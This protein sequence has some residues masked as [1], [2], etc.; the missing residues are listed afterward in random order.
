M[1]QYGVCSCDLN[2]LDIKIQDLRIYRTYEDA[3]ASYLDELMIY[4]RNH[5][6]LPKMFYLVHI[7]DNKIIQFEQFYKASTSKIAN[8]PDKY[9]IN[10]GM[11]SKQC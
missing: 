7:E 4:S 9:I 1:T 10:N 8:L 6:N 11:E 3:F 2:D 5:A